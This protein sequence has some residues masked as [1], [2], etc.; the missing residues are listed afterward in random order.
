LA[1]DS[2][3]LA[4]RYDDADQSDD[5]DGGAGDVGRVHEVRDALVDDQ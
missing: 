2:V 3:Q 5:E 4:A 1:L